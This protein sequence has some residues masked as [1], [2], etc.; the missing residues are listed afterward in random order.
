MEEILRDVTGLFQ[1]TLS[2][3]LQQVCT[4]ISVAGINL[5]Q[6]PGLAELFQDQSDFVTS[7]MGL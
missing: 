3:L 6:V 7:F 2:D 1:D 4:R 5:N